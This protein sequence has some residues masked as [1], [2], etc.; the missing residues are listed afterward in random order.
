[1]RLG[2]SSRPPSSGT[3]LEHHFK[4]DP[5]PPGVLGLFGGSL[6]GRSCPEHLSV[7]VELVLPE[8]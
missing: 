3:S 2:T 4:G 5:V 7:Q 8:F 6:S 1:M